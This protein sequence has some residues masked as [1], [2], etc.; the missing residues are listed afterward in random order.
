MLCYILTSSSPQCLPALRLHLKLCE[1]VNLAWKNVRMVQFTFIMSQCKS[2]TIKKLFF[3]PRIRT[4]DQLRGKQILFLCV[5]RHFLLLHCL[6][7]QK[8]RKTAFSQSSIS[9]LKNTIKLLYVQ[10]MTRA[11]FNSSKLFLIS[12][13]LLVSDWILCDSR[14]VRAAQV[15]PTSVRKNG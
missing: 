7:Q 2:E 15:H 8:K 10:V 11:Q 9:Y 1:A 5:N 13:V 12:V 4:N 14:I 6:I 3:F